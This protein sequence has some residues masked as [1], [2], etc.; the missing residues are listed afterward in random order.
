[1]ISSESEALTNRPYGPP[2][3]AIDVLQRLRDRN[4]PDR[5]DADFLRDAGVSVNLVGRTMVGL[6]FLGLVDHDEPT[7]AL[8]SIAISTD[9]DYRTT[10]EGLVRS[11]Y[12]EVFDVLDPEKDSQDTFTNFFRR[13]SP[14]SQRSR[15]VTFFLGMCR[16]AGL[17]V[18]EAP[19]PRR[20][21]VATSR[22]RPRSISSSKKTQAAQ[23]SPEQHQRQGAQVPSAI[24]MLVASLPPEGTPLAPERREQWLKL[25]GAALEFVYPETSEQA[26]DRQASPADVGG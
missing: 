16:E 18:L 4:L 13:Y 2:S 23:P 26:D 11:A 15:M 17:E 24:Q 1:M 3:N 22:S 20:S 21:S 19:K 7:E 10:L 8:R 9:E 12:S 25:A 5:V 14:A 6:Q